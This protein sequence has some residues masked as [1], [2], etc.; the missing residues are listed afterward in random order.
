[1]HL[2][3]R[4]I[5]LKRAAATM[6]AVGA[7]VATV[8]FSDLLDERETDARPSVFARF[9]VVC[10]T[11]PVEDIRQLIRSDSYSRVGHG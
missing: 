2:S 9:T 1:M 8:Q 4:D 10:L 7:D 11:E 5:H 6:L 3:Q